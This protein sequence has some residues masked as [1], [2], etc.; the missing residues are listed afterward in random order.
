MRM[1]IWRACRTDIGEKYSTFLAIGQTTTKRQAKI[2]GKEF[3]AYARD[4]LE[5]TS[6]YTLNHNRGEDGYIRVVHA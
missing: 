2:I 3:S 5:Q 4:I 6:K 1:N